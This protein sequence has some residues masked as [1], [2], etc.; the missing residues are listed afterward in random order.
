MNQV[1]IGL[2]AEE[3]SSDLV[4]KDLSIMGSVGGFQGKIGR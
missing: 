2:P 4:S 1:K 3:S